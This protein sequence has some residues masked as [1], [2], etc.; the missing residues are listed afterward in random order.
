MPRK[1]KNAAIKKPE[2]PAIRAFFY[3]AFFAVLFLTIYLFYLASAGKISLIDA[4]NYTA[5]TFSFIFS[6]AVIAYLLSR[7]KRLGEIVESL[8]L[9]RKTLTGKIV[10]AGLMLFV[11][12]FLVEIIITLISA[13]TGVSLSSNAQVFEATAP[14]AILLFSVFIAPLNEEIFFRGFL[15]PR[16]GIF[17]PALIFA[18]LHSGYASITEFVGAFVFGLLA[19]YVFQKTKSL[20]PSIIAHVLVN[21]LAVAAFLL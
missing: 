9:S 7:G 8:G 15:A 11:L 10:I 1:N 21:A 19:G 6:T 18:I 3:I 16:Y 17:I 14:L 13:L 2:N 20:Y 4:S 5:V 12:L